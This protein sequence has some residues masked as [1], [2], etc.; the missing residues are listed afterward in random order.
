VKPL[1]G[2]S[3]KERLHPDYFWVILALGFFINLLHG[4]A[5]NSVLSVFIKP[6]T[7]EF[8]WSRSTISGVATLGAFGSGVLGLLLGPVMEN[9]KRIHPAVSLELIRE[10]AAGVFTA[11]LST[12]TSPSATLTPSLPWR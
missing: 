10:R 6:M 2:Y 1:G 8:G 12:F 4:S 7:E 11:K 5:L 3:F 9:G